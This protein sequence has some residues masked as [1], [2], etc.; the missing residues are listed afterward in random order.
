VAP[1][2]KTRRGVL[3]CLLRS[4]FAIFSMHGIA[5]LR[6]DSS[7]MN[8][9][10]ASKIWMRGERKRRGKNVR[11]RHKSGTSPPTCL[12]FIRECQRQSLKSKPWTLHLESQ[13]SKR[14]PHLNHVSSSIHLNPN[15]KTSSS[16][17]PCQLQHP[18]KPKPQNVILT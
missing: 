14:H 5:C 6:N 16:P 4:S 18:P 15:L 9:P 11:L 3:G 10:I 13:T 8:I 7:L 12:S 17:E 2:G 1:L